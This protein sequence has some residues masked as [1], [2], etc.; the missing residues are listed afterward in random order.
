MRMACTPMIRLSAAEVPRIKRRM[1]G[2]NITEGSRLRKA[3]A[4]QTRSASPPPYQ[5]LRCKVTLQ[6]FTCDCKASAMH[7]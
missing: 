7:C 4:R 1:I 6:D 2:L 5:L 3:A